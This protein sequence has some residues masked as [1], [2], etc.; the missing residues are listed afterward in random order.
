MA[1]LLIGA[2]RGEAT[3]GILYLAGYLRRN[4]V[5]AYV[6]LYDDDESEEEAARSLQAILGHLKPTLVGIS[7][8][9]FNHLSRGLMLARLIRAIDPEIRIAVGGNSASYYW[10]ELSAV[11]CIDEIVLGDGE[12]PLLA[13]CRGDKDPPNVVTRRKGKAQRLP[14]KYVQSVDSTD[15]YYSGFDDVF[16][17]GL[18]RSS[19]SGWIQPGKGC[20]E[21]C[22]YCG[23]TRGMEQASFGRP[24]SFLRPVE[25]VRR[26]HQEIAARTWQLRYDFAGGS[27]DFLGGAWSSFD[28]KRHSATYFLW[29]VPPPSLIDA[30]AATFERVYLVLDVGCFAESQRLELMKRGL[31]KP[32]PTDAQ[33]YPAVKACVA[34]RNLKLEVCG[35]AG[36]PLSSEAALK[37][38]PKVVERLLDL[39][40]DVGSQR[41]ESQPGALV[42]QH[43][44]R[45]GM[46]SDA[47]TFAG[48]VDWFA[49]RD[50][51]THGDFPM[52]R[53]RE[54]KLETAVQR[55]ADR[56]HQIAQSRRPKPKA[57]IS[58]SRLV[59]KLGQRFSS[60]L[61]EWLGPHLVPKTLAKTKVEVVRSIDGMGLGCAP[62]LG[63][64]QLPQGRVERGDGARAILAVLDA[65][66][67]P[68]PIERALSSLR[69][70]KIDQGLAQETVEHLVEGGFLA[71]PE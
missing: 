29:G 31:L 54:Q 30:L 56:V 44:D 42:T 24:T 50:H 10:R 67:Q 5:E 32:C 2:G 36:L 52:V 27:A 51:Q 16:L 18:D 33:L 68:V 64:R 61:S 43:A 49:Q 14:L 38:E 46:I 62:A 1:V 23:G 7:F 57:L 26:D 63:E 40:C 58:K 3:C 55:A 65:F 70:K 48:F 21:N 13:L 34:H 69:S 9:W 6:R 59:A 47:T 12:L 11:D 35:I 28:L 4:G 15:V 25:S 17:S 8:K 39:G 22:L 19:F 41:L 20:S 45:F 60:T 71:R 53:Y 66:A 37:E